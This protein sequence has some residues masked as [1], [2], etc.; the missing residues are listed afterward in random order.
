LVTYANIACACGQSVKYQGANGYGLV[1]GVVEQSS[2]ADGYAVIAC[3]R[4]QSTSAYRD[5]AARSSSATKHRLVANGDVVVSSC[6]RDCLSTYGDVPR[7]T[8]DT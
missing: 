4:A 2:I 8:N 3:R 7:T 6:R 5:A 1:S